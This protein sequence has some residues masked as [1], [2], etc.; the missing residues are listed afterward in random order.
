M[1]VNPE[2]WLKENGKQATIWIEQARKSTGLLQGF[3]VVASY[4]RANPARIVV[5]R[6]EFESSAQEYLALLKKQYQAPR[7]KQVA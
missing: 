3:D 1:A 4:Y 7:R 5:H 2:A 6:F